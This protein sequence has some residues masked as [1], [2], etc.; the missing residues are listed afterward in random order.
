MPLLCIAKV[1]PHSYTI[2]N[3][4]MTV[5]PY[6]VLSVVLF[7]FF[8]PGGG[9]VVAGVEKFTFWLACI[10]WGFKFILIAISGRV[11]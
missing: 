4:K 10:R 7:F 3:F 5:S 11:F 8:F 2:T 6:Q 1:Y 9:W